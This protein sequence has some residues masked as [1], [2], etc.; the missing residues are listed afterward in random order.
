MKIGA[1]IMFVKNDLRPL[2]SITTEKWALSN[3][4]KQENFGSFS[5]KKEQN[6]RSRKNTN[7]KTFVTK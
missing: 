6:Y 4:W 3:H 7:G 1:Q 5:R 2:I